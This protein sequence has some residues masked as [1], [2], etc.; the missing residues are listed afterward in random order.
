MYTDPSGEFSVGFNWAHAAIGLGV[1]GLATGFLTEWDWKAVAAG[2]ILGFVGGGYANQI[3]WPSFGGASVAPTFASVSSAS[4]IGLSRGLGLANSLYQI[5]T[6][7][8]TA[9]F[10]DFE[11][12]PLTKE[13]LEI[14][15]AEYGHTTPQDVGGFF[16]EIFY[17][18]GERQG[19]DLI[20]GT[21]KTW[22]SGLKNVWGKSI[23]DFTSYGKIEGTEE[24]VPGG[25]AYE[26]KAKRGGLYTSTQNYQLLKH[27]IS[28]SLAFRGT[29]YR[30]RL[31]VVTTYDV[32]YSRSNRTVIEGMGVI[33]RHIRAYYYGDLSKRNIF[34][35]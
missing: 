4:K 9:D 6:S 27:A 11:P 28:L 14:L 25:V 34:F 31:N 26:I 35:K 15:A 8:A 19:Y 30:P 10:T 29:G 24:R 1:G 22:T 2:S 13:K 23:P 16:E 32:P 21:P 5:G 20:E 17:E 18:W 33:Y 12:I 3:N 7:F